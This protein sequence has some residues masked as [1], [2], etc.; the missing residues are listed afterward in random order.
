MNAEYDYNKVWGNTYGDLRYFGPIH[1]HLHRIYSNILRQIK[2]KSVA[3]VGC[4]IHTEVRAIG[5][6]MLNLKTE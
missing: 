3:D 2:Y 1:R 5:S 6:V 4:G